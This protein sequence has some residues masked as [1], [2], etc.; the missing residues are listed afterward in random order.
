MTLKTIGHLSYNQ[1][2]ALCTISSYVNSNWRHDSEKAKLDLDL[3]YLHLW[4]LTLTFCM[5]ITSVI[6]NN[7]WKFHDHDGNTV[8]KVWHTLKLHGWHQ[9][10]IGHL[11][12]RTSFVHHFKSIGEFKKELQ[13]Q[14]AQFGSKFAIFCPVWPWNLTD[15]LEK[16]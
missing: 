13:S 15:D 3:C 14:N 11:Y 8:K 1:H 16:Q 2:Q 9:K 6:G 7:S 5:D 4:P 12:A 10:T